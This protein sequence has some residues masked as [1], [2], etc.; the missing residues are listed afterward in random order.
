MSNF[1]E[2]EDGTKIELTEGEMKILRTLRRLEKLFIKHN[3]RFILFG[4]SSFD[5]RVP[6]ENGYFKERT[7]ASFAGISCDG[8]DGGD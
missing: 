2:L 7:L 8:G 5:L 3:P 6:G 4:G 1:F